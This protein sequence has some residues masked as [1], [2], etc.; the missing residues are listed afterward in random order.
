VAAFDAD[1]AGRMLV[2]MVSVAVARVAR[3][4]GRADLNFRDHL[5]AREGDDWNQVLKAGGARTRGQ[6]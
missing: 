4:T 1:G 2:D 3:G 6:R 5:P